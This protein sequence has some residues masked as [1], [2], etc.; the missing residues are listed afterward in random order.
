[1]RPP[2]NHYDRMYEVSQELWEIQNEEKP[3]LTF[4]RGEAFDHSEWLDAERKALQE[5]TER[6]TQ[7]VTVN[8][9]FAALE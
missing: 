3:E 1:M 2:E 9:E 6:M 5:E 4:I 7:T 8:G